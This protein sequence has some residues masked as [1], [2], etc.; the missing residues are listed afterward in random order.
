MKRLALAAVFALF[1][2]GPSAAQAPIYNWIGFYVGIN[3]GYGWGESDSNATVT[4]AAIDPL[5]SGAF[6]LVPPPPGPFGIPVSD[7]NGW[8]FGIQAGFNHQINNTVFGI[9]ADF[10][11]A[12][13]KGDGSVTFNLNVA[14]PD[15]GLFSGVARAETKLDWFATL[16]GRLGLSFNTLLPYITAGI[17]LGHIETALSISGTT[18]STGGGVPV[19]V[20]SASANVA[21]SSVHFGLAVGGGFDW[22]FAEGW[23]FRGEYLYLNLADKDVALVLPGASMTSIGMDVQL[24]RGAINYRFGRP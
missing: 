5:L 18:F 20:G 1:V 3:G 2:A 22:A 23:V 13:I 7:A 12:G 6:V 16:R 21:D 4:P 14:D 11:W 10:N 15:A 17:A 8:L 9:E 19:F 24:V